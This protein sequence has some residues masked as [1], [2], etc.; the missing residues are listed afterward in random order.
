MEIE[1]R[2]I[3][4]TSLPKNIP[5]DV[6]LGHMLVGD[7]YTLEQIEKWFE[8]EKEAFFVNDAGN[9][10]LDPWY[11]YMRY[12]NQ[13]IGFSTFSNKKNGNMLVLGP[14]NG[15][16]VC[17]FCDWSLTFVEASKNFAAVLESDFPRSR[18]LSPA[19]SGSI[20]L[21][22]NSQDVVCAFS[23]LH[24]I[25]NVSDI[26]AEV[27]RVIKTG[28]VFLVREPCSS[29]GD[30]RY[31]RSAT[32]NERG[33]PVSWLIRT[34]Q[35]EGLVIERKVPIFFSPI[36]ILLK[37]TVGILRLPMFCVYAVDR[38]ISSIVAFN[39]HYW[40]DTLLKRIGPSAYFYVFRKV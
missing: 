12:V 31:P 20:D 4:E 11:A 37:K 25:P 26:V 1:R 36:N 8:Q 32:P 9:S 22:S 33:L 24:H 2:C 13:R 18:V 38:L 3:T 30:W 23:V 34:A 19:L 15:S 14:G 40:R 16:E 35:D 28:G 5:Q 6:K 10:Y 27:A 21:E 7:D 29:M 39:D 17:N